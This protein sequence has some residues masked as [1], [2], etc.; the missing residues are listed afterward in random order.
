MS[1]K[2]TLLEP[3]AEVVVGVFRTH[4]RRL[5]LPLLLAAVAISGFLFTAGRAG[6]LQTALAALVLFGALAVSGVGLAGWWTERTVVTSERV[7][8]RGGLVRINVDEIP[9]NSI[10]RVQ[11][12]MTALDRALNSGLVI[13]NA[14]VYGALTLPMIGRPVGL[15]R[16]IQEGKRAAPPQARSSQVTAR[17]QPFSYK[18]PA[19]RDASLERLTQLHVD[20]VL[21]DTELMHLVEKLKG[22]GKAT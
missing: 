16:A 18:P 2:Q 8:Q 17:P 6:P 12:T 11:V 3:N 4:W 13:I 20:G 14:G 9:L 19:D 1:I 7:F 5:I 22:T 21:S 10:D 15:Q